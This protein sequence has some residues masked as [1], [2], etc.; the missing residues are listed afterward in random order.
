MASVTQPGQ[1]RLVL[2]RHGKAEPSASDDLARELTE[3]GRRDSRT[4]GEQLAREQLT[5]DF[6]LVSSAARARSTVSEVCAGLDESPA[7]EIRVLESLY[8]AD[9]YD[10][11]AACVAEIPAAAVTA[12]VVGHN[13]TI[14]GTA[15]LL[16]PESGRGSLSFPTAAFAVLS[17]ESPWAELEPGK[18]LLLHHHTPRG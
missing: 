9:A 6:I 11:I 15:D 10:V 5:P 14:A 16:Q 4:A 17:V 18:G 13:P 3:R 2:M 12:L 8:E 1:R 7:P